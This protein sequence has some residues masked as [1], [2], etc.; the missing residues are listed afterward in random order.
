LIWVALAAFVVR[1]TPSPVEPGPLDAPDQA[2]IYGFVERGQGNVGLPANVDHRPALQSLYRSSGYV[3]IWSFEARPTPQALQIVHKLETAEEAGLRALDYDGPSWPERVAHFAAAESP[4]QLVQFDL[5]LSHRAVRYVSDLRYG[6]VNP[7]SVGLGLK[8][9][10]DEPEVGALV[11]RLSRSQAIDSDLA[12]VEP[13]FPLYRRSRVALQRYLALAAQEKG[14]ALPKP[15]KTVI[16]IDKY[17][18]V[19]RLAERLKLLGDLPVDSALSPSETAEGELVAALE[20]FQSRHGI[21]PTGHIDAATVEALNVPLTQRVE[22]LQLTLERLRWLPHEFPS[23]PLVVNIPQF[24][25]HADDANFHWAFSMKVVV[26]RS[27]HH[28]TPVFAGT[29][30]SVIFR[31]YWDVPRDIAATEIIP[32]IEKD[33]TVIQRNDYEIVDRR[34]DIVTDGAPDEE[35][36]ALLRSGELRIRQRPGEHNALGTVKFVFPNAYSVYLHG[37]PSSKLF[38]RTRRDFS[39]GC[40]RVEDPERLAEWV[41]RED[42]S[43]TK[44]RVRA[45]MDGDETVRVALK[46][47]IPVLILYSTAVVMEDGEV[48]FFDDIYGLDRALER[49]LARPETS[50][51]RA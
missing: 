40:I 35:T 20:R 26:G 14:G 21:E 48:R 11:Y 10:E 39:H 19:A 1:S 42:P 30:D 44:D 22:Q 17:S 41:L 2:A 12:A 46:T 3:P 27:W 47:P 25:L 8:V 24:R 5:V 50:R 51:T 7:R 29:L 4:E 23:P 33:P 9:A 31:P 6:R 49:A 16:P 15:E 28:Q 18:D 38:S 43:W 37:T 36:L 13:P 34:A 32:D 45:A